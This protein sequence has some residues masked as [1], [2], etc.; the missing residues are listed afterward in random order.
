[1]FEF[2]RQNKWVSWAV[3]LVEPISQFYVVKQNK[4]VKKVNFSKARIE[5]FIRIWK[6]L[7]AFWVWHSQRHVGDSQQS[8]WFLIRPRQS[9][10]IQFCVCE[11]SSL[12]NFD[13]IGFF[14]I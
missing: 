8:L 5:I 3:W 6:I 13:V 7:S 11:D 2:S 14:F 4:Q 10:K 12:F 9:P 1:M